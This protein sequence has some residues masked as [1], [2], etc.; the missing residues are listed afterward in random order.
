MRLNSLS[1]LL[2]ILYRL[3]NSKVLFVFELFRHGARS[4][5]KLNGKIDTIGQKWELLGG[6]LTY[7]GMRMQ[8]LLG[9]SL[10]QR[11]IIDN[12]L[13]S[14]NFN[15][16][17][18]YLYTTYKNRTIQSGYSQLSGLFPYN[19]KYLTEMQIS[20]SLPPINVS[21]LES[22]LK[23]LGNKPMP[24]NFQI[25]PLHAIDNDN[26]FNIIT[27]C[28]SGIEN[29]NDNNEEKM[30]SEINDTIN[31]FSLNFKENLKISLKKEDEYFQSWVN[32]NDIADAFLANDFDKRDL[33][34]LN[35]D[36]SKLNETVL[37]LKSLKFKIYDNTSIVGKVTMSPILK[38]LLV[39]MH[40]QIKGGEI[41]NSGP[42]F[43][44]Y[45]GHDTTVLL[46][47]NFLK[48]SLKLEN[49]TFTYIEYAANVIIELNQNETN[50]ILSIRILYNN[51]EIY[52]DE[53]TNFE[54]K[55][56]DYYATNKEINII[57]GIEIS[58][59]F[60]IKIF[61]FGVLISII[62]FLIIHLTQIIK[63]THEKEKELSSDTM[64]TI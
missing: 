57:C 45:S 30:L 5:M 40:L 32:L 55:V 1:I 61:I 58:S 44:L 43:V 22:I 23:E 52:N 6:E 51:K 26:P 31:N 3:I 24:L 25:V 46:M 9:M 59:S 12:P 38:Q 33:N 49:F 34:Y 56:K 18:I 15:P 2:T 39:Y 13:L 48:A 28:D 8:Y 63:N 21:D 53:M 35:V 42:K 16:N 14:P 47:L 27:K 62:I 64:I 60:Q 50:K 19:S 10:R 20:N 37:N 41:S 29:N 36:L 11:Y 4:P 54:N 7:S 17:E